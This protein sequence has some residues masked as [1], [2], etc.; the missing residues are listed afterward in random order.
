M[1]VANNQHIS[2]G[3]AKRQVLGANK[4]PESTYASVIKQMKAPANNKGNITPKQSKPSNP[5]ITQNS[6]A[7][8]M[9]DTNSQPEDKS[10]S[11]EMNPE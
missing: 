3:S 1:E 10:A 8:V 9:D 2:I 11:A 5:Q 6:P 7:P 4:H